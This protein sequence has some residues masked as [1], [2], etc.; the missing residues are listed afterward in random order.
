[1]VLTT[2]DFLKASKKSEITSL[3]Q[4]LQ[5]G[6]LVGA[7]S[8][9][10]H[11]LQRERGTANIYL[12]SQGETW[13]DRLYEEF[14]QVQRAEE[15]VN[16]QLQVLNLT[17]TS[18]SNPSRLFSRIAAVLHSL[19]TLPLLRQQIQTQSISQPKAMSQYCEVI[20]IHLALIFEAADSSG[21][22]SISRALLALFS[23]MQGKE[24]AGQERALGAAG[25]ATR[26]FDDRI[27]QQ[28]IELIEGQERCFKT[29]SE[30]A[31]ARSLALWQ[32][33][34]TQDSS[35]FERFRRIACTRAAPAT[36]PLN[37]ALR[38]FELTT[39][40]IDG[41]KQLEDLLETALME[42]CCQRIRDAE[43]SRE[44]QEQEIVQIPPHDNN[45][46]ALISPQLSLSILELVEQ[47][48]RQLQAQD[49]ELTAL[50]STLAER[51][52]IE[53]AKGLLMQHHGMTEPQAHKTLRD[54]A[55]KQNKKLVE[56]A[57]ALL[58]VAAVLGNMVDEN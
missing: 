27:N 14:L 29:F 13:R 21:D 33:Q 1:M 10:I 26:H 34:L 49:A 11:M 3:H 4:L 50:R 23:F 40:R 37:A 56:I 2:L 22:P 53:R 57:E 54:M 52:L 25:F 42:C 31:D 55:M 58:A 39:S 30:F 7:V 17:D 15:G 38:W 12:C 19:S 43:I 32:Q 20:R 16:Q 46:A 41:M 47:Q 51:K 6:K 5:M 48:A 24:L 18:L 45:Y 44:Q 28:L 35:E 36:K 8:Q 9:L